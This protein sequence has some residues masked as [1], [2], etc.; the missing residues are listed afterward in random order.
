MEDSKDYIE[1]VSNEK[2]KPYTDY[3]QKLTKYLFKTFKLKEKDKLL[4]LGCGR[5]EFLKGFIDLGVD[6]Y[7]IDQSDFAKKLYPSINIKKI[8]I[9]ENK[10]LPYPDNFFDVIYSKF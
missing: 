4:E 10:K 5:G 2:D 1:V 9:L 3:P 8:N 6:A 7:A